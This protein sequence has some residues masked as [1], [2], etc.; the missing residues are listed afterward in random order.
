MEH[1]PPRDFPR[2]VSTNDVSLI[3]LNLGK[4]SE[5]EKLG[6]WMLADVENAQDDTTRNSFRGP[7]CADLAQNRL[8]MASIDLSRLPNARSENNPAGGCHGGHLIDQT[9]VMLPRLIREINRAA[10]KAPCGSV[11]SRPNMVCLKHI[12]VGEH[13]QVLCQHGDVRVAENMP[14]VRAG[15]VGEKVI[16]VPNRV[17]RFVSR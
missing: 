16:R 17:A 9:K 12:P 1:H 14:C 6:E 8:E 4:G 3:G 10:G 13:I 7:R 15:L 5:S 2:G 11:E